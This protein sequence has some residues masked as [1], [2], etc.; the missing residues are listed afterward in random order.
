MCIY[1]SIYKC[2]SYRQLIRSNKAK[3]YLLIGTCSIPKYINLGRK[4]FT[5][6]ILALDVVNYLDPAI[7]YSYFHYKSMQVVLAEKEIFY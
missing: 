3:F 2:D 4:I 1:F 5:G 7:W 6:S